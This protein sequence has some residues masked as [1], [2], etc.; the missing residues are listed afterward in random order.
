MSTIFVQIAS[1]R[2]PQLIPTIKDCL[3]KASHPELLTFGICRQY[4]ED[5]EWDDITEFENNPQ[6]KFINVKWNESKGACWARS[7]VQKL[8]AGEDYTLQLDSHHRFLKGWDT[9]L[10]EMMKL[11]GSLKP[12]ITAYAGVYTP[13]ENKLE[14]NDPYRMVVKDKKFAADGNIYFIPE[15]IPGW[16]NM[17][18]PLPCRFLSGH[19]YFTLG[20]HCQECKYDPNIYFNGEELSLAVRSFTLG[21][22]LFH[23]H[24][25]VIWHEYTREGRKKH[26]DDF[27]DAN[28]IAKKVEKRWDEIDV[29][30]MKRLRQLLGEEDNGIDLGEY[31]LGTVRTLHDYEVYAGVNFKLRKLHPNTIKSIDPPINDP[32]FDWYKLIDYEIKVPIPKYENFDF[33]FVGVEDENDVQLIRQDITEYKEEVV[34][35]FQTNK[36]PFKTITWVHYRDSGWGEK[37]VNTITP[38][39]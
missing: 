21:Y 35:K 18:K 20:I 3:E 8:W 11:T 2:D 22:D 27:N 4:S 6:F 26:W 30:S 34:L 16:E 15:S 28:K 38:S 9:E 7:N 10:F 36:T 17:T 29:Q 5:D 37:V 14:N 13:K 24:K 39:L 32:D 31:I 25:V 12:I 1:Y 23:P 33:M 19:F